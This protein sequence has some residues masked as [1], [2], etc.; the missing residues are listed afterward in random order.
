MVNSKQTLNATYDHV[1]FCF[2]KFDVAEMGFCH[3]LDLELIYMKKL[4]PFLL[5]FE[6]SVNNTAIKTTT[7]T[8][9]TTTTPITTTTT[10]AE[11]KES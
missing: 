10:T 2:L 3:N 8:T 5:T 9:T 1:V 7:S 4:D 11:T 6:Q